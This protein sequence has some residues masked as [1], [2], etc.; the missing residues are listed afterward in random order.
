M[1]IL[2]A[3]GEVCKTKT[4]EPTFFPEVLFAAHDACK[5]RRRSDGRYIPEGRVGF[6]GRDGQRD[7]HI[8]WILEGVVYRMLARVCSRACWSSSGVSNSSCPPNRRTPQRPSWTHL[9]S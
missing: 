4:A 7:G 8:W 9:G 5:P 3:L 2:P 6:C 1:Y